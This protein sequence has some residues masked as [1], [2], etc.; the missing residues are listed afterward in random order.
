M[1]FY[2][3]IDVSKGYADFTMLNEK[4]E[5]VE[6]N[7]QLD[8]NFEGHSKLYNFLTAFILN[9]DVDMIIAG[10]ESTGSLENNWHENIVNFQDFIPIKITRIN[11]IGINNAS[12][13]TMN[14]NITDAISSRNIAEFM[15]RFP[16]RLYFT[17]SNK[18][19]EMKRVWS[20]IRL[21]KKQKT[22]LLNHLQIVLY[23]SNPEILKY[24]YSPA[25]QWL[26]TLLKM[27]PT[28]K[29]LARAKIKKVAS[30]PYVSL[31]KAEKLIADAKESIA[32]YTDHTS[33]EM[34]I[35]TLNHIEA[36]DKT[37]N[38][39]IQKMRQ[40]FDIPELHLIESIPGLG[41]N[42]AV[43]LLIEIGQVERFINPKKLASFFGVHPIFKISGDGKGSFRMSKKGRKEPRRI[44]F[45]AAFT[46]IQHNEYFKA[47]YNAQLENGMA[48]MAAIGKV[49]HKLL[50][51]VYGVLKNK[52]PFNAEI[53]RKNI[54]KKPSKK[55]PITKK[56]NKARRF[57]KLGTNAPISNRQSR[58]RKEQQMA[59]DGNLPSGAGSSAAQ[60]DCIKKME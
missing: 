50:R 24:W 1:N 12:K 6:E 39:A 45:L 19:S 42:T 3:G 20:L 40:E 35:M 29:K 49:M 30:I 22:Q 54:N 8:D 56:E 48:K 60:K 21:F 53:D 18:M 5:I 38:N 13:A 34:I 10:V 41:E 23:S 44:L 15:I 36:L 25:P 37:I 55:C 33:E 59:Q 4:F 31:E 11:P 27:Y 14:R 26:I 32:S 47:Y 7:F 46:A 52:Q 58:K 17:Q 9:N 16:E 57:Q 51:I 2:L 28:A 43:G